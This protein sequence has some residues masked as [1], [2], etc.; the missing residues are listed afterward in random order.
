VWKIKSLLISQYMLY[1]DNT[2][3]CKDYSVCPCKMLRIYRSYEVFR[4]LLHK[5][6]GNCNY[7]ICNVQF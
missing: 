1:V 2:K 5:S 4:V 6:V 7:I 3:N